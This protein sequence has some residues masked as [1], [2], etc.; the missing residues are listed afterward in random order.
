MNVGNWPRCKTGFT[1]IELL[2]TIIVV[3]VLATMAIPSFRTLVGESRHSAD[4][5]EIVASLSYARNEAVKRR[6]DVVLE[7][8]SDSGNWVI[9][10]F[11]DPDGEDKEILRSFQSGFSQVV[12]P[13]GI[14]KFNSSGSVVAGSCEWGDCVIEVSGWRQTRIQVSMSGRPYIIE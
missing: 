12:V 13:D 11:I 1:L 10:V 5:N 14:V 3:V 6:E 7:V 4:V 8:S 9:E 2:V